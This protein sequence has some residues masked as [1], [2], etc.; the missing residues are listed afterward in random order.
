VKKVAIFHLF[1]G[2]ET[3]PIRAGKKA[4]EITRRATQEPDFGAIR[5]RFSMRR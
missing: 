2:K 4:S 3:C 5:L 1:P